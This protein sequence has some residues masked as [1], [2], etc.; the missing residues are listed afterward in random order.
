[1][2]RRFGF[3]QI[4]AEDTWRNIHRLLEGLKAVKY[5]Q[6]GIT[7]VQGTRLNPQQNMLL[8]S[9]VIP[10]PEKLLLVVD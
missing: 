4:R 7:I 8:L 5:R 2:L 1:M 9:L 6:A 3:P 10:A